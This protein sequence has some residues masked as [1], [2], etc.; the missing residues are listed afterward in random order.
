MSEPSSLSELVYIAL[1]RHQTTAV[2]KLA[3]IAQAHELRITHTMLS[4]IRL[5]RYNH[6]LKGPAVEALAFL[7]G[8]PVAKVNELAD[9]GSDLGSFVKSVPDEIDLL[10]GPAR[11]S[12]IKLM[13]VMVDMEREI[14]RLKGDQKDGTSVMP[15]T[16]LPYEIPKDEPEDNEGDPESSGSSR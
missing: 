3:E 7:S 12:L 2:S 8:V 10:R 6:R 1:A 14:Q 16:E 4:Q 5:R 13:G 11:A 15:D 9:R